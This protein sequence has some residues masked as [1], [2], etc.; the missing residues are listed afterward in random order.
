MVEKDNG[1]KISHLPDARTADALFRRLSEM[2]NSGELAEGAPLP[3]ER[4]IVQTYGVSRTVVREAVLALSNKGLVDAKPRFR[5]VV[6]KPSFDTAIDTVGSVVERLLQEPGGIYNLFETRIM[7][8][9]SLARQAAL[10]ATAQD[11]AQ[12]RDALRANEASIEDSTAF[13]LT[14]MAFHSV[15]Y[16]IPGN[17]VLPAI[18][19]AYVNWLEPQWSRMPR[20]DHRNR[21][22]F[23]AHT[24]I[25]AAIEAQDPDAAEAAVRGHLNAAW[26]QVSM[27]FEEEGSTP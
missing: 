27:T 10:T 4:E 12:M 3:P 20:M 22:N 1:A 17:P 14:D 2:I 8:E 11:L 25:L 16:L 6:R 18:H 19:R 21:E 24:A 7:I 9:V 15:L 23:N 13:Y 26:S 5:P